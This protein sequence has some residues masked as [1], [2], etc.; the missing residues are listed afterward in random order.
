MTYETL[1]VERAARE[2][3]VLAR[4]GGEYRV[5]GVPDAKLRPLAFATRR[6]FRSAEVAWRAFDFAVATERLWSAPE[7]ALR[8]LL[9]DAVV[10]AGRA[11]RA[12][13]LRHGD[14]PGVGGVAER[15]GPAS[16]R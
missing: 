7:R 9:D 8:P 13:A 6:T 3:I 1:A 2:L 16:R 4:R 14:P 15:F 5:I 11:L 10:R 12:A